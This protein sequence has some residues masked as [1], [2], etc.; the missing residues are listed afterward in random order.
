MEWSGTQSRKLEAEV[1]ASG[2]Q[3]WRIQISGKRKAP[4]CFR[5]PDCQGRD[6]NQSQGDREADPAKSRGHA[7][8]T[9]RDRRATATEMGVGGLQKTKLRQQ[10]KETSQAQETEKKRTQGS[11][12]KLE[13]E[14]HSR[15]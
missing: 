7:G 12:V 10:E 6:N 2:L 3:Q 4:Q 9:V 8:V 14:R 11:W 1:P 5:E 13:V 15:K